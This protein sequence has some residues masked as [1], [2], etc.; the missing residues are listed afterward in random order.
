MTEENLKLLEEF[1]K[2]QTQM[3]KSTDT[4]KMVFAPQHQKAVKRTDE[5][6]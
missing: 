5:Q 4:K 2:S 1:K 6:V 3:F